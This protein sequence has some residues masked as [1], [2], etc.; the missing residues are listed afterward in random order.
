MTTVNAATKPAT[1]ED[2]IANVNT[3]T[4]PPRFA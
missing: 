4:K 1:N 3:L 2:P